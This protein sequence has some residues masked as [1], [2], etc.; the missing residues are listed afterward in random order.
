M[1]ITEAQLRSIIR[2]ELE[3][4]IDE[5]AWGGHIGMAEDEPYLSG[6]EY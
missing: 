6:R 4:S 2:E 5:M 1:R 3:R